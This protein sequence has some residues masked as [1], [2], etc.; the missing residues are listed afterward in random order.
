MLTCRLCPPTREGGRFQ[1]PVGDPGGDAIMKA[2]LDEHTAK[3]ETTI[4]PG[5]TVTQPVDIADGD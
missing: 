1:V 2:H 5:M 4:V 3:G